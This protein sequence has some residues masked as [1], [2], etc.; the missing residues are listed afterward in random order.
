MTPRALLSGTTTTYTFLWEQRRTDKMIKHCNYFH[1]SLLLT[2]KL[3][4]ILVLLDRSAIFQR[5][6]DYGDGSLCVTGVVNLR[7]ADGY[8]RG[9]LGGDPVT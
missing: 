8:W 4:N 5:W 7:A 6:Q 9:G 3:Q 1:V 2:K